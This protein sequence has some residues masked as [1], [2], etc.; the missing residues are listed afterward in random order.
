[1]AVMFFVTVLQKKTGDSFVSDVEATYAQFKQTLAEIQHDS[2]WW[3][4][5]IVQPSLTKRM[6]HSEY[7]QLIHKV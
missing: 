2:L 5:V 6:V 4:H 1:M 7:I 3:V